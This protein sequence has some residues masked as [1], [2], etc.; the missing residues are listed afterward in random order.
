[1]KMA[2]FYDDVPCSP[3]DISRRFRGAY[4]LY[5]QGDESPDDGSG[6]LLLNVSDES[7]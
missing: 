1:M 6:K 3:V 7:S 2:V 5:H 4:C